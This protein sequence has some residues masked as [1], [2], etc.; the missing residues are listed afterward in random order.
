MLLAER[1]GTRRVPIWIG[2][3]EAIAMAMSLE[4]VEHPR[5]MTYNLTASILHAA[6]SPLREVRITRLTGPVFYAVVIVDG[7]D[8][9]REVDARPSDA[10][11]LALVAGVAIRM[12]SRLFSD[13][14]QARSADVLAYP[15]GSAELAAE[16]LR[17]HQEL[18]REIGIADPP[19]DAP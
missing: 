1:G 2:P 14:G 13:D 17:Q 19:P 8:G 18:M 9:P 7:P 11:S 4:S 12:D 5:P 3:A 10:V 15:T 16:A 6:G